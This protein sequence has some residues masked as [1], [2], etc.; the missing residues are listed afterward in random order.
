M[1]ISV[2]QK[3]KEKKKKLWLSK[4]DNPE[5]QLLLLLPLLKHCK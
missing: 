5:K 2:L 3:K 1:D 4:I